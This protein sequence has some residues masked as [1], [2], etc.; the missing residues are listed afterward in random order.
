MMEEVRACGSAGGGARRPCHLG[1]TR[2]QSGSVLAAVPIC[3]GTEWYLFYIP[4]GTF[5]I[6]AVDFSLI[7]D[8]H[9]FQPL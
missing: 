4:L 9:V 1:A 2:G 6:S 7:D 3:F 8:P 5:C